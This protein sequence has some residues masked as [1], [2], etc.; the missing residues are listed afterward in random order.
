MK[1]TLCVCVCVCLCVC[2]ENVKIADVTA[3]LWVD[4]WASIFIWGEG[5][6]FCSLSMETLSYLIAIYLWLSW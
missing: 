4:F 5:H 3:L 2:V 1:S 6:C